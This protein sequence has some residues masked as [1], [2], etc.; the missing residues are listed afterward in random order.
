MTPTTKAELGA[1]SVDR[2]RA[3]SDGIFGF[4][5]TVLVLDLH[6]PEATLQRSNAQFVAALAAHWHH[7]LSFALS[8][9]VLAMYWIA[10]HNTFILIVRTSRVLIV[11]NFAFLFCIVLVPF[12]ASFLGQGSLV[13]AAV[14]GYGAVLAVTSL[15]MTSL[16]AY[17]FRAD[18]LVD[19]AFV[20]AGLPRSAMLRTLFPVPIYLLSIAASLFS[21]R[22]SLGLY[23][24]LPIAF[25]IPSRVDHWAH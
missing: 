6:L 18:G 8:F 21:V 23:V 11:A 19:P 10:H 20:P 14:V 12:A 7:F 5:M 4:A 1:M 13:Q 15:V 16:L 2:L 17:V 22:L 9:A 25:L 3:L 24:C